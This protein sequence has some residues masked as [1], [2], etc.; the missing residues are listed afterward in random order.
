MTLCMAPLRGVTDYIFRNAFT[1][2]FGGFDSAMAPFIPT[3]RGKIVKQSHIRDIL[4][5]NNQNLPL[6]PQLIGK[7]PEEFVIL[8]CQLGDMGYPVINWNLGCPFPQVTHKKRG[9]G[10]LPFRD[11]I[12]AFLDYVIPRLNC[13]L[14]IKTR[15]GLTGSDDLPALLPILNGYPLAELII[16]PRTAQQMYTGTTD[17]DAFARVS[18]LSKHPVMYNGDIT[19]YAG[20][21]RMKQRFPDIS[22]WMIGR[23]A[24][25]NPFLPMEIK[26]GAG[27][28][29]DRQRLCSFI[30]ALYDS[31]TTIM[32][33]DVNVLDKM[34]GIWFY[35]AELFADSHQILKKI[36]KSKHLA[37][38]CKEVTAIF[39][40]EPLKEALH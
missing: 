35:T 7:N 28:S 15:L 34:K 20:F 32:D 29:Y 17:L 2:H 24:V 40:L 11:T 25:I 6:I 30:T 26:N 8:A 27:A 33:N 3:V 10:L 9:A 22:S 18:G 16:H 4:P 1:E 14:S 19:T 38:Y 39:E 36:Q 23:G 5:E 31:Y 13:K 12:A 21:S 37:G